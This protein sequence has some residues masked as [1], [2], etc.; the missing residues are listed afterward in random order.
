[1]SRLYEKACKRINSKLGMSRDEIEE[2]REEKKEEYVEKSGELRRVDRELRETL[3]VEGKG[4]KNYKKKKKELEKVEKEFEGAERRYTREKFKKTVTFTGMDIEYE[5]VIVFSVFNTIISFLLIFAA[6]FTYNL[7]YPLSIFELLTYVVPIFLIIPMVVLIF[8]ANYPEILS[9]RMKASTIGKAPECINYM[10]MSMR[11][12]PSLYRAVSFSAK[13][14]EEPMASGLKKVLWNIHMNKISSLEEAFLEFALEWGEWNEELKRSL[15]AVRSA[16]LEK[17]TQGL[18]STLEKANQIII[19]GTERKVKDY[20]NS[21]STPT[22]ILFAIGILLP[23]IIGAM[24]PM[25]ALGGLDIS[26]IDS[27]AETTQ[28][29]LKLIHIVLLMNVVSPLGA[30]VYSYKILGDRPGTMSPPSVECSEGVRTKVVVSAVLAIGLTIIFYLFSEQMSVISPLHYF[31]GP[32]AGI[33]F[34]CLSTTIEAKRRRD[35][36]VKMERE[37]PDLLFQLGSRIAEGMPPEKAIQKT[38]NAI[39]GTEV[40]ELFA[41]ISIRLKLDRLPLNEALFGEEGALRDFPSQTIKATMKTVVELTRK[42]PKQAGKTILQI[43][44]YLKDMEEMDHEIKSELSSSVGMMKAT[45]TV[46]A[47]LVMGIVG[48]LY[49]MLESI[50]TEISNVQLI[51]P[52]SFIAVLAVYLISMS[53]VI[54]YFTTGIE[55][56]VD[57]I[58][59]K[60]QLGTVLLVNVLVFSLAVF[61]GKIGML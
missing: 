33:S 10:T 21:L 2:H 36:V 30:F 28:A 26:S 9:E 45:S 23:L 61:V 17:T 42:N 19:Q 31:W 35:R 25:M 56:Q 34:Y 52:T 7:F 47:P 22:T 1:M 18:Y 54:T 41:D 46:F 38:S 55:N 60:Y 51:H 6:I 14:T 8:T 50:F 59:F 32:V 5:E 37:F 48:A 29:G 24:L 49:Y 58:E 53:F 57:N 27:S 16:I 3:A 11:V 20:A 43:S 15:Y 39:K 44:Q 40:G 13:N 12:R 4:S